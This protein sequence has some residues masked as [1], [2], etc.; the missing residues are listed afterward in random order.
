VFKAGVNITQ[1]V[2][3]G[4]IEQWYGT[5][6]EIRQIIDWSKVGLIVQLV[7]NINKSRLS[8][9][10]SF[11]PRT[12]SLSCASLGSNIQKCGCAHTNTLIV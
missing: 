11:E 7:L 2:L 10:S 1:T 6:V 9:S 3:V 8:T 5:L 4:E 12:T